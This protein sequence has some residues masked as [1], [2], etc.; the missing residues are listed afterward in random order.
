MV[1]RALLLVSMLVAC[2]KPPPPVPKADASVAKPFPVA[3]TNA[4]AAREAGPTWAGVPDPEFVVVGESFAAVV[5]K[6]GDCKPNGDWEPAGLVV[7]QQ[8]WPS[9]TLSP[10]TERLHYRATGVGTAKLHLLCGTTVVTK[11]EVTVIDGDDA[12]PH[13]EI[14]A[15]AY[16]EALAPMLEDAREAAR[17]CFAVELQTE[18]GVRGD[19]RMVVRVDPNGDLGVPR[20][21]SHYGGVLEGLTPVMA[22]CVRTAMVV[23]ADK[24]HKVD[25]ALA[26]F[27]DAKFKEQGA[28]IDVHLRFEIRPKK[29]DATACKRYTERWKACAKSAPARASDTHTTIGAREKLAKTDPARAALGWTCASALRALG[30]GEK[31]SS[32]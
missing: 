23:A 7:K 1:R 19:G 17:G 25:V 30:T 32:E 16:G 18:P 21:S 20:G 26:P 9:A 4:S 3:S 12:V 6:E 15:G 10:T 24:Q 11:R 27:K 29:P 2:K 14:D 22:H 5:K 8:A 13:A 31:C 28:T